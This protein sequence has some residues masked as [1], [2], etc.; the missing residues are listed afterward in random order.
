LTDEVS[1]E[2]IRTTIAGHSPGKVPRM[3]LDSVAKNL[4]KLANARGGHD[5]ITVVLMQMPGKSSRRRSRSLPWLVAAVIGLLLLLVLAVG[6]AW[7]MLQPLVSPWP[8]LQIPGL[9]RPESTPASI[10]ATTIPPALPAGN[11]PTYTPW[12]TNTP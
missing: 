10:P 4:V 3:N 8:I 6:L 11:I 9:T 2:D 5:N 12:P 7:I 1:D